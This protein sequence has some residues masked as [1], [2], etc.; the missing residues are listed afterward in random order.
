MPRKRKPQVTPFALEIVQRLKNTLRDADRLDNL[1]L[2]HRIPVVSPSGGA[3]LVFTV[4]VTLGRDRRYLATCRE[5]PGF[6]V[7]GPSEHE[8]LM[9]AELE[10]R[11][12][13]RGQEP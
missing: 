4:D 6:Y 10:I 8:V 3:S 12:L 1:A 5:F 7:S 11:H 2:S 13:L 9:K